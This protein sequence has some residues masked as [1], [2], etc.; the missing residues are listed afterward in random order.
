MKLSRK[1]L[2]TVIIGFAFWA[3]GSYLFHFKLQPK[4]S[5]DKLVEFEEHIQ[6]EIFELTQS[7]AHFSENYPDS[8]GQIAQFSYAEKLSKHADFSF[9]SY[10]G[11]QLEVWT[12]NQVTLPDTI[13]QYNDT[14]VKLNNGWYYLSSI[15]RDDRL[16][17][18]TFLIK[19]EYKYENVD[20]VNGF[21]P[22]LD[23]HFSANL[24][25]TGEGIA[26][27][28]QGGDLLFYIVPL[29]QISQNESLEVLIFLLY[30]TGLFILL[31]LLI[32]AFQKVLLAKP[33]LLI[34]FPVGIVLL[35][36][37]W[38]KLEINFLFENFQL[39]NPEL[40][41]SS[42]LAPSLGDLAINIAIFYFIVH[43]LLKRTRDWFSNGNQKLKLAFVVIP[44]FLISFYMAFQINEIIYSL[45][46]N[47]KISFHLE[48]LFELDKYSFISL[49]LIGA[50]FYAYFRLFQ[51]I[52]I[53]LKI[54]RFEWNKLAFLWVITSFIYIIIDQFYF[55]ELL[56]TS[57]WPIFLSGS[58]LWFHYKDK[59]IKF[60]HVIIMLA[61][62]AFY[63]SYI[64]QG[65]SNDKEKE[66]RKLQAEKIAHDDDVVTEFDYQ[67]LEGKMIADRFV[68][69]YFY[70]RFDQKKFSAEIEEKYYTGL[71]ANYE[72]SFYLFDAEKNLIKDAGNFDQKSFE[73][74]D[75][76]IVN[77][78]K[79]SSISEN[80]FYIK[81][82][83]E[84]INYIAMMT[85]D[86]DD[87]LQG[88]LVT[89][90]RSKNFPE[91]I[92]LPSLLLDGTADNINPLDKYSIAKY[93][94][95][96]LVL[97]K[98]DFNYPIVNA[99]WFDIDAD[100]IYKDDY[101][102][103][104][105]KDGY[106][107]YTIV[108]KIDSSL[109]TR[110]TSFSYLLI[111]FGVLLLFPLT[112]NKLHER[113]NFKTIK[114]NVKI[115]VVLIGLTLLSLVAFAIGA[116]T[117]VAQQNYES[118]KDAIKEKL[119]SVKIELEN[120][121]KNETEL[122]SN[123]ADYLAFIS[124]KF[125][126]VFVTDVNLYDRFGVLLASSQPKIY[127]HGLISAR[128]NSTAYEAIHLQKQSEL[129]H[130]EKVGNLEYLS[131]YMP[132]FNQKGEF[133]A[134][135]NVQYI[136][137]QH[138]L[139]DQIS[140]LLLA[141]INIMVFMLAFSTI[142]SIAIS[143]RLIRPLRE[144]QLSLKNVQIGPLYKPIVYKNDDEIGKLVK[145]YNKKV[146]ELQLSAEALAKSERESAWREMAKQVAHEIKNPL[147]PMKLSIQHLSRS[148]NL[149]D[150]ESKDKLSRVSK[151]LIE[152]INALTN[153]ANEFSNFAKMP[154]ANEEEV[155]LK[156]IVESAVSMFAEYDKHNIKLDIELTETPM[157]W[158]DKDLLLRVFN[159][160]IKNAIQAVQSG[161]AGIIHVRLKSVEERYLFE[162][163]DN[164]I[165][166]SDEAKVKMF[167][168]YFTTKS[169]GTGL[170][171]AMSKQIVEN[172]KGKI[173]F[174]SEL[175]RGTSFF[176]SFAKLKD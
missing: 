157:I 79:V 176:V 130:N 162:V 175:G 69:P 142:L 6:S 17:V 170:G 83:T 42:E 36:Y 165:G 48:H 116:G 138:D 29:E 60:I 10:R 62:I 52:I 111:L 28:S 58:L 171:L 153:I 9:F 118:N 135:V 141:I 26:I 32:N 121:L 107:N 56:L 80:L 151:S 94:N 30:L 134:Y 24:N 172:L 37:F 169:K 46:Y 147:T 148:I 76:I 123:L 126:N 117:Y 133:L 13:Q 129:I 158:A 173:W 150:D 161:Q 18:G 81:D 122:N 34:L 139:E 90:F 119:G 65:Y 109:L 7:L 96:K 105:Y 74:Y 16:F 152:Q 89:E 159:N 11:D 93:V 1:F 64:L 14:V 45:V 160:L 73:R 2:W 31:Q 103:Y 125:S 131:A 44:L 43:F 92:G 97:R 71:M 156:D 41:A 100:F 15:T 95:H 85:V 50:S 143:N 163:K 110:F 154:K 47:S 38:L 23:F 27:K 51:Y 86:Y 25:T 101:S 149:A 77:S 22:E 137:R 99:S 72:L 35:R 84:K 33:Y 54:C 166:I 120:K 144:I 146:E 140:G 114:L 113:I 98:G 21:S 4:F 87:S 124:R 39:F 66:L 20:L 59:D 164:G 88:Y 61:F 5:D 78:G 12:S 104:V 127:S 75:D 68:L 70:G 108:S 82:Y 3:L 40:F 57:F 67:E 145:E 128:M 136:S 53:Q 132:F 102:H 115:Q 49:A 106:S 91:D 8:N 112:Y 174:E 19:T 55:N 168:P 155:N 63:G 167:V